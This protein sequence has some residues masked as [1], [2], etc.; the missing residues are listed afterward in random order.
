MNKFIKIGIPFIII[1]LVIVLILL[2]RKKD[3]DNKKKIGESV[4]EDGIFLKCPFEPCY[5]CNVPN[6]LNTYIDC[7]SDCSSYNNTS[8][9]SRRKEVQDIKSCGAKSLE[10]EDNL[11]KT[12]SNYS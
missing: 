1:I 3:E 11:I 2:L 4:N 9:P 8:D 7:K 5:C 6:G 10:C 12:Y